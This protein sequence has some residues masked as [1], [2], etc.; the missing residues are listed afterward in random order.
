MR[1][2]LTPT[3][4]SAVLV[5][6]SL[7]GCASASSPQSSGHAEAAARGEALAGR[8]CGSCHGMGP[9]GE[10][11]LAGAAPMRNL[12]LDYNAISYTRRLAQMHQGRVSMPPAD[13]TMDEL[14]D[15]GA[16]IRTL[17]P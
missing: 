10:S 11:H 12:R 4:L 5:A 15:I 6:L 17:Q 14:H 3:I 16:Y 8:V 2:D 1:N 13:I 7:A 9:A